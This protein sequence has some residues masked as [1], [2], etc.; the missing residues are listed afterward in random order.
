MSLA[1]DTFDL[2]IIGGGSGGLTGAAFAA[3]L[4]A[5]VALLE[6]D[7]L[8]GDCTWTGCVPSKALVRA[9]HVAHDMAHAAQFGIERGS[10]R[11]NMTQV[12]EWVRSAI[13]DAYAH[14]T[15]ETL[16]RRGVD[17]LF[18]PARFADAHTIMAGERRV[19]AKRVIICTGAHAM[20]PD[21]EGLG[22]T[23][24]L[25]YERVFDLATL[26]RHLLVVGAGPLG[27]EIAQAY[28]RLGSDVTVIGPTILPREE[29]DTQ[30]LVGHLF[31]RE[32]IRLVRARATGL[33]AHDG[34]L[35]VRTPNDTVRGD[36][37][38]VAA[39]RAP[40]TDGLGLEQANVAYDRRGIRVDRYLRTNVRHIYACGDV[41]G[42]RQFTHLA[43]WQCFQ[44]VRNAL[45]PGRAVGS[46]D[47]LPTVTF[48]DPEVAR[49]GMT[50]AEA[51][52]RHAGRIS[53]HSWP[54]ANTDRAICDG[55]QHGFIKLVT[56]RGRTIVGA[57]IVATRAGEMI[58]EIALAMQKGL[59]LDAIA[60]TVHAYPTWSL[61][62]QQLASDVVTDRFIE[63]RAGRL[64]R[65]VAGLSR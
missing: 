25:T 44:A 45:L 3:R 31:V 36:C 16:A 55:D 12:R 63:S 9:A 49:V 64:V 13:D 32:G 33:A 19:T 47:V 21:I 11:V 57:T 5:R 52:E 48:S 7:R 37:V 27:V 60:G 18:G 56:L 38:L 39:G 15:P 59:P 34:D 8:G 35:E 41:I 30:E 1:S 42:G 43:G 4:G 14:E 24:Y 10:G 20:V 2:A 40:N 50:E 23:P 61:G 51:R 62:L 53:V 22:Q 28:R 17:V 54:I 46:P 29:P 6:K 58:A 26:P 65:W